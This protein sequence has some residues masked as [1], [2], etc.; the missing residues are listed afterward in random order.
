MKL[1]SISGQKFHDCTFIRKAL[2][3]QY[4]DEIEKLNNRSVKKTNQFTRKTRGVIVE[5][6]GKDAL[7]PEKV[8]AIKEAYVHRVVKFA[9]NKADYDVRSND[10]YFHKFLSGCISN[11]I[12]KKKTRK[13][14]SAHSDV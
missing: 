8:A 4:S 12:A 7:T 10:G 3:M 9:D 5:Y 1:D 13:T 11:I 6:P 2:E 14:I